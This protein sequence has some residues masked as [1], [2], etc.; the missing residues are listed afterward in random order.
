MAEASSACPARDFSSGFSPAA[1]AGLRPGDEIVAIDGVRQ[2]TWETA[3]YNVLVR[4][5]AALTLSVLRDG[6][7]R[8]VAVVAE[9]TQ[10][11]KV[12]TI[13]VHPLV[14]IGEVLPGE[15]QSALHGVYYQN[16]DFTS[17]QF[18]RLD[19]PIDL[20]PGLWYVG[21]ATAN[22]SVIWSGTIT[23]PAGGAHAFQVVAD[24][25]AR[26]EVDGQV[27]RAAPGRGQDI[28]MLVP[29]TWDVTDL[30]SK[31]ARF[32]IVD[33]ETGG[34]GHILVDAIELFDVPAPAEPATR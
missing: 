18:D 32:V 9:A 26:L 10:A 5:D 2:E 22:Y 17:P 19:G 13:G 8:E 4:P 14:R 25:G 16:S 3:Q 20:H 31:R 29:V 33:D 12:G 15:G 1:A 21:Y 34:W 28:E 27:V 7:E 30:R 23:A 11:E 24:D 6:E